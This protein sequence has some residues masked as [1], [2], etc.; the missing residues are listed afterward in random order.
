MWC[1]YG[2]LMDRS[3]T[4][5]VARCSI[6]LVVVLAGL[7]LMAPSA[8]AVAI[9]LQTFKTSIDVRLNITEHSIWQ[10]IRPGCYAP[11]EDFDM[12]YHMSID[13]TPRGKRSKIKKGTTSLT[14]GSF[15]VTPNYGDR[16]SFEQF[17]SPGQWTLESQYPGGCGSDPA[18]PPPAWAVS[19][20]CKAIKERVSASLSQ[21]TINDPND[22]TSNLGSDDGAMIIGRS[23]RAKPTI[24][25]ASIGDSCFRTLHDV[26]SMGADSYVNVGLKDTFISVPIPNLQAKLSRLAKGSARSRPSFRVPIKVSGT[27]NAMQMRP[28]NGPHPDF[29]PTPFSQPHNALGTFNGEA[30]R[31]VCTIAGSGIAVVRREGKVVDTG[32][33]LK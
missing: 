9:S 22:P 7:A 32:T 19:P 14:A 13:S 25:G 31:T 33:V 3:A 2:P 4:H 27:C 10:G 15:G 21:N 24:H 5:G 16:R 6:V 20:G 26:T 8:G 12:R 18:P 30:E 28:S 23:P 29:F 17:S 11:A 1:R